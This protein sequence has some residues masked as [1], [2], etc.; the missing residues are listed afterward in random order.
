VISMISVSELF[1]ERP[2]VGATRP[3]RGD[4]VTIR[5]VQWTTGP[6]GCAAVRAVLAQPD[7]DLVGAFA[8]SEEKVGKDVGELCDLPPMGITA[9]GDIEEIVL[10]KPDV[11][12]YM[13]LLWNVDHMVRLLESGINVIATSNFITGR[14]Y[15]DTEM[16][17]LHEAAERGGASLYGT[18]INPGQASALA[19]TAAAACR[20]VERIS[21]FEASDATAYESAETW[22]AL[23]V[24]SPPDTPGLA[25]IAKQRQ[26]V[27]QDV[28][29]MM[30]HLLG[31]ELDEVRYTAEFGLATKDLDLGYMQ[32]PKGTV[33]G[34]SGLW[35]GIVDG[36]PFLEIGLLWRLGN[37][38]EPDWP[39]QEGHLIEVKGTPSIRLRHEILHVAGSY[40][41][42]T[43]NPAVNAIPAVVAAR[44]GLVTLGD[45]PLITA[46]SVKRG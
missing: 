2:T 6:V 1:D 19:L 11:V 35:Q 20:E 43:A 4:N 5:V 23:G 33:C 40:N 44:P 8:W 7:L 12:L 31:V 9:S 24:G 17:R 45:L 30:A 27:F 22:R 28:I 32:I 29:E 36:E 21:I 3:E 14:S 42:E 41:S 37:A 39:I 13:P 10:L 25:D 16:R 18:G 15:G 46:T 26:L 34:I 38:M